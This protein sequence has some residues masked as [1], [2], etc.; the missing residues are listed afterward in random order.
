MTAPIRQPNLFLIVLPLIVG[1]LL[2]DQI[3]KFIAIDTLCLLADATSCSSLTGIPLDQ[4]AFIDSVHSTA[5][6][7]GILRR[8]RTKA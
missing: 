2:I 3:T 5:A 6:L 1:V 8:S 4:A 7:Q